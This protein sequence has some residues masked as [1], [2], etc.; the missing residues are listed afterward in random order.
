M[1]FLTFRWFTAMNKTNTASAT[2]VFVGVSVSSATLIALIWLLFGS[3]AGVVG[4]AFVKYFADAAGIQQYVFMRQLMVA[5]MLLP[6]FAG[7]SKAK[8]SI[9]KPS[10][11]LFRGVLVIIGSAGAVITLTS[12]SLATAHVVFYLAPALTL[13]L[14]ILWLKEPLQGHRVW[15]VALC[16]FGVFIA[17]E[18]SDMGWGV[19]AGVIAALTLAIFNLTSR[20]IPEETSSVSAQF[21]SAVFS[22]PLLGMLAVFDWREISWE[23]LYLAAGSALGIGV[24]QL[25]CVFAYRRTEAG[26]IAIAEYS[27]LIFAALLGWYFFAE[28]I[29]WQTV[30]GMCLI[31]LPIAWQTRAEYRKDK[32]RGTATALNYKQS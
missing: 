2:S 32:Q 10:L 4:D 7:Q 5:L 19:I 14:A 3:F 16:F 21:W 26:A 20:F 24:Y 8:R 31:V 13:L 22:L 6:F 27:G 9:R 30:L 18:P 25:C 12:L 15:A 17:L 23:L 28:T 11:Y 1:V 29:G